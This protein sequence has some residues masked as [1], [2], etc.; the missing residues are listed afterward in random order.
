MGGKGKKLGKLSRGG[1]GRKS[2]Q[3]LPGHGGPSRRVI[4]LNDNRKKQ[5]SGNHSLWGY[6]KHN[7]T[8]SRKGNR[9]LTVGEAP[10]QTRRGMGPELLPPEEQLSKDTKKNNRSYTCADSWNHE[11]SVTIRDGQGIGRCGKSV[12]N[13]TWFLNTGLCKRNCWERKKRCIKKRKKGKG[14]RCPVERRATSPSKPLPLPPF[15]GRKKWR[16]EEERI[17]RRRRAQ[18]DKREGPNTYGGGW[19]SSKRRKVGEVKQKT[20]KRKTKGGAIAQVR[21]HKMN[22]NEKTLKKKG[23]G[24]MMMTDRSEKS[25]GGFTRCSIRPRESV[26]GGGE[27]SESRGQPHPGEIN[28]SEANSQTG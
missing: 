2:C 21:N 5:T 28:R 22:S 3:G 7:K 20:N 26:G 19:G 15:W 17:R 6:K 8:E 25:R 27:K 16:T 4:G 24:S 14:S 13:G 23:G 18:K 10:G 9:S 1:Q 11:A 12:R